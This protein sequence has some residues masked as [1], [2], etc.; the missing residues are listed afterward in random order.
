M[1]LGCFII[2]RNYVIYSPKLSQTC[3]SVFPLLN[4]KE[5]ILKNVG[6]KQLT[7]FIDVHSMEGKSMATSK[8]FG[9]QHS[10]NIRHNVHFLWSI[11]LKR[12]KR[13]CFILKIIEMI[14]AQMK[15]Y[16]MILS[17]PVWSDLFTKHLSFTHKTL[18]T[19][20]AM[21]HVTALTVQSGTF[22]RDQAG[23]VLLMKCSD[24]IQR[25]NRS[26]DWAE[27]ES[28]WC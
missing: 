8:P 23:T 19:P 17:Q 14:L 27:D 15:S 20:G 26:L 21:R 11:F 5:D 12:Q 10:S 1:F 28:T 2:L 7:V 9:Y 4:T 16:D 24:M 18:Y 6:T 13:A 25:R 22:E 3:M